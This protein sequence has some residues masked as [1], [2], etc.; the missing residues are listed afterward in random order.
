MKTNR[1]GG[2]LL[3]LWVAL[4]TV[5]VAAG[6]VG[7][8]DLPATATRVAVAPTLAPGASATPLPTRPIPTRQPTATATQPAPTVR[9]TSTPAPRVAPTLP[10]TPTAT[11]TPE[12][13]LII[14]QSVEGRPLEAFR[15]GSGPL[16]VV[17]VGDIHGEPEANTHELALQLLAYFQAHPDEVPAA[18]SL[19]IIPTMNPDGLAP[20]LSAAEGT[21]HRWNAHDVDLNRN[22]DTDLDG[23]GG[24]DWSPDTSGY[25]GEYAGAGGAYPF[26]EPESVAV[27]DFLDDAWIAV[28]Y[29]SAAGAIY[30]DSCQRHAPTA[31]LAAVLAEATGYDQPAEGW[32]GYPVTGDWGDY[33]AGEGVA[34]VTVELSD[35]EDPEFE[36]NL[37]GVQAMLAAAGDIVS[38]EATR[39]GASYVWLCGAGCQ[40]VLQAPNTGVWRYAANSFL[41]PIALEVVG[42]TA[43]LLDGGR[44]LALDLAEPAAPRLLLAPGDYVEEVRVLE[45]L[46]LAADGETLLALDRAGDVYRYDPAHGLSAA[47]GSGAW[48]VDRYDRPSGATYD[49]YFVALTGGEEANYLLETTHEQVWRFAD[50]QRGVA[51]AQVPQGRDVDLSAHGGDVYVL[52]RALNNPLAELLRYRDAG[53]DASF[54]P[55]VDLMHP[56]QVVATEAAVYV[57]DRAGR[58]LLALDP[59]SGALLRLYQFP[60]R[61]AVSA[62]WAD[63]SGE[64]LILA[65][66]EALYFYGEP[67][68]AA[69]IA[70]GPLLEGRQPHDLDLLETLRG[71]Q[72][73]IEGAHV[74][75]RDFQLPGA[76]RH[77]RLG[78]HEGADWYS[79]TVGVTVNRRTPVRAVADGVVIRALV[80]YQPLTAAQSAA[81]QAEVQRLGYTPDDV[82]DGYRGRQVWID[83]GNGLVSRYAHLSSI[84]PGIVEGAVVTKGQ[85]IA[86]V[87]NSGTPESVSSETIDVHLHLELWL[88]DPSTISG[89]GHYLGQFLRPIEAREWWERI[90]R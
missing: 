12:P 67:E 47:E 51:W 68:R 45:P 62:V 60:D 61:R 54:S 2:L 73:P 57:L 40:P 49:H 27:R 78:V 37:A 6:G 77:Y 85:V 76:P 55:G 15:I 32:T 41:H 50:G 26:S 5:G 80:D 53:R 70:G 33:L 13:G 63:P 89:Q 52:T 4:L 81:W 38:E 17:L 59:E 29:H 22:A 3:A 31:R 79:N 84:A 24:N 74:T 30:V 82:L 20:A 11:P 64:R 10:P 18:V 65:G 7:T 48:T 44:V 14:G 21:G 72:V 19:W 88:D 34:A 8:P 83:H 42:E 87:G 9:P 1:F 58:R 56:R 28:F 71:L 25:E 69:E 16:K 46:D 39:A 36:R 43:Y 86:M 66:R 35:H 90:L 23:C 75:S